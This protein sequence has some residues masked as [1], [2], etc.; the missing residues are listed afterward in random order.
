MLKKPKP[1]ALKLNNE[2]NAVLDSMSIYGPDS[3]EYAEHIRHLNAL[4]DLK[5][6]QK[7]AWKPSPDQIALVAGNFAGI[8][9]I[10]AYEHVHVVTSKAISLLVKAK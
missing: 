10:V 8:L 6:K 5:Q 7:N 3:P 4:S 9:I 1:E 2:I